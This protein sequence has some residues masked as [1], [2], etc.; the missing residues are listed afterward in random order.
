MLSHAA[1][2]LKLSKMN[3]VESQD[4][5]V[6]PCAHTLIHDNGIMAYNVIYNLI[7]AHIVAFS[8]VM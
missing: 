7:Q 6:R 2:P 4:L 5:R 3:T 1:P 8:G